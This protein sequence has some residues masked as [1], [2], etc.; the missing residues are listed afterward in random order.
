MKNFII[1]FSIVF[2]I[3]GLVNYYIFIRGWQAIPKDSQV[4]TYYLVIFL[5]LALA[6][7][8]G[9]VLENY[10]LSSFS[11]VFVWV[12]SFW[13][14]LMVYLLLSVIVIDIFRILNHFTGIFPSFI[15]NDYPKT[16]QIT[17]AVVLSVSLILIIAGRIN[18]LTPKIEKLD[19][20]INKTVNS[21]REWNIVLA[22]DIHMGTLIGNSHLDKLV[23]ITNSFNPDI[24]LFAG[25]IIDEDLG[26]V[27]K[28]DLGAT[29][30]NIKSK[31]GIYAITGNHEFIGGVEPAVKYL[32][33][34]GINVLRDSSVKIE[35]SF[36]LVGREDRST[37]QFA[38][39]KRK[40]L[41]EIMENVDKK[42]PIIMMD[43]QPFGLNEAVENGVDLQLSGHTHH[44]Q[45]WPFNYITEMVYELSWGYKKKGNTHFYVSSGF[46]GWGPPLKVGS[47]SEIVNIKLQFN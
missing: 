22:S 13:L 17:A 8:I 24:V 46:G 20:K 40:T 25:D 15:F 6:F 7:I 39:K 34:H 18:A 23:N 44:G 45:L 10:Y 31:Y 14:G 11:N 9:R 30:K 33:E 47:R 1:F 43:H 37:N 41:A 5:F 38:H 32:T 4:R 19:L 21:Q 42:F 3:Y 2:T 29:L 12:G 27:I 35:N 16:K 36:Y 28:Q 26:P